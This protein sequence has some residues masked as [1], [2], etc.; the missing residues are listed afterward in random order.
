MY[1]AQVANPR[2]IYQRNCINCEMSEPVE[3]IK[4]DMAACIVG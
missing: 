2:S 1:R 4:A 3:L